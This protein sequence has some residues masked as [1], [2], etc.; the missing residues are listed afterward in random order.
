MYR[1]PLN[2]YL[3]AQTVPPRAR[4]NA[5]QNAPL[6]AG[7]CDLFVPALSVRPRVLRRER[8]TGDGV[9]LETLVPEGRAGLPATITAA[10][11][12]PPR[13]VGSRLERQRWC[14]P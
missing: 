12:S 1:V 9:A 3:L 7:L 8:F 13:I 14:R 2:F 10:G 6:R 11:G 4:W 5:A